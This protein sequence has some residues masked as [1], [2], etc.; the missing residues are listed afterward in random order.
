MSS[1]V[2][3]VRV[4]EYLTRNILHQTLLNSHDHKQYIIIAV[5]KYKIQDLLI[6]SRNHNDEP[7]VLST[8]RV[9]MAGFD[10][11]TRMF[12]HAVIRWL[13]DAINLY[14][15]IFSVFF[16]K[17]AICIFLA[18]KPLQGLALATT[19]WHLLTF[20]RANFFCL[21]LQLSLLKTC[22]YNGFYVQFLLPRGRDIKYRIR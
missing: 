6:I 12:E 7:R 3:K 9:M 15:K 18:F 5:F 22:L 11:L 16:V 19:C 2:F 20:A 4:F 1:E 17:T 13:C 8:S 14:S 10:V 21:K